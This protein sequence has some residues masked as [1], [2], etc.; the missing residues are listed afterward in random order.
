MSLTA[1]YLPEAGHRIDVLKGV[2]PRAL[3]WLARSQPGFRKAR[4]VD[5]AL[6]GAGHIWSAERHG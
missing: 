3:T 6:G 1:V 2:M 5:P 4:E